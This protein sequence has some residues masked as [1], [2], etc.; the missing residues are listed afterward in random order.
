MTHCSRQSIPDEAWRARDS[1]RR[2]HRNR[3]IDFC[4]FCGFCGTVSSQRTK[5]TAY[6]YSDQ[7][8]TN[9]RPFG[10]CGSAQASGSTGQSLVKAHPLRS[11][12]EVSTDPPRSLYV[13]GCRAVGGG[14][15][16]TLHDAG[17]ELSRLVSL[18][19]R[20]A[21]KMPGEQ[22]TAP[23]DV[24]WSHA[25]PSDCQDL[26][27]PVRGGFWT[28]GLRGVSPREEAAQESNWTR[29]GLCVGKTGLTEP[30]HRW[31]LEAL[32]GRGW[33]FLEARFGTVEAPI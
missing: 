2:N 27:R 32:G 4:G 18:T 11:L 22:Q 31:V 9:A 21:A 5:V 26:R 13:E 29:S 7:S 14:H 15:L 30:D 20:A 10:L 1:G 16:L 6:T 33:R 24:D 3:R 17:R 19:A 25:P 8:C 23:V 12:Y 28:P